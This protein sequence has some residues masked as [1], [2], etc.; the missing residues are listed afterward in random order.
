LSAVRNRN[1]KNEDATPKNRE[2]PQATEHDWDARLPGCSKG[3][4]GW[5]LACGFLDGMINLSEHVRTNRWI[6][7]HKLRSNSKST[8]GQLGKH[9]K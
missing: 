3:I 5:I 8:V 4:R 6:K 9:L 1:T 7:G 2:C